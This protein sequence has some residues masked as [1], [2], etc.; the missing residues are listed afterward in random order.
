MSDYAGQGD[1][2]IV[3]ATEADVPALARMFL[4]DMTD[5]GESPELDA[6]LATTREIVA[7][8]GRTQHLR[9]ARVGG[10]IAGVV[11]A[12]EFLSIKFPG[13]ALWI[14]ELYVD[15]AYRR[16]GLGRLLIEDLL[17]WAHERGIQG[18]ELE[19]Y[20]MNTAASILYR[21]L[22]FR[23]L[24]RERY[25]FRMSEYELEDEEESGDAY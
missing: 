6:M 2:E 9:V 13:V 21:T 12:N 10:A 16:L 24:A 5:L 4:S 23:R 22:G 15:P 3:T 20:R 19:A 8:E 1:V 14:E 18:V 7:R 17:A 11:L 25:A